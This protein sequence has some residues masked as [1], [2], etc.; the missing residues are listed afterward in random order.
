MFEQVRGLSVDLE[1]VLVVEK[2]PDRIAQP[3]IRVYYNRIQKDSPSTA[4]P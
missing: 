2:V 1:G 4:T 3:P